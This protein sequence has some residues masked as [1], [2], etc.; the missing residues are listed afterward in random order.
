MM[1][2]SNVAGRW[3]ATSVF[4]GLVRPVMNNWTCC[5]SDN[6]TSRQAKDTN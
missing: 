1:A 6:S 3:R 5:A 2:S 4:N